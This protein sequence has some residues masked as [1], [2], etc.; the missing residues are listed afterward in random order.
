M[1]L[2]FPKLESNLEH[3]FAQ[4]ILYEYFGEKDYFLFL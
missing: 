3:L 1:K 2:M 4:N